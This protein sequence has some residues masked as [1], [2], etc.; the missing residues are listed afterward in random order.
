MVS[1]LLG[2]PLNH[3][4]ENEVLKYCGT[5]NPSPHNLNFLFMY[6]LN[7]YRYVEAMM[8]H[9]K[10]SQYEDAVNVAMQQRNVIV[11][12][13]SKLVPSIQ[14]K[15]AM[16]DTNKPI[17]TECRY[18]FEAT[19]S[20]ISHETDIFLLPFRPPAFF[21]SVRLSGIGPL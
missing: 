10:L 16:I 21:I 12:S 2:V 19:V 20:I 4:L 17:Q 8:V 6:Y 13:T 1:K 18:L 9:K 5:T 14:L 3:K 15:V 11:D 7:R